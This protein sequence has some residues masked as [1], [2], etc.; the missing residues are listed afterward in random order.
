MTSA[1]GAALS[2]QNSLGGLN[3]PCFEVLFVTIMLWVSIF[4]MFE[5]VVGQIQDA[6][7]RVIVYAC[8]GLV[9]VCFVV[10]TSDMTFCSL[11]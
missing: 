10:A 9:A 4:G 11:Q 7:G 5:E 6:H 2:R 8:I 1:P 3:E